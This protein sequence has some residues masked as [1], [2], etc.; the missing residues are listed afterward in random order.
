MQFILKYLAGPLIGAVIGYCTNYIAVKM[1][2]FPKREVRVFGKRLPFTPGAIPKG[3][4]RLARA[5]GQ[6]VSNTLI[7]KEDIEERLL[8]EEN[9][10]GITRMV[11][12]KVS[13]SI[14]GEIMELAD[15]S[16]ETYCEKR[17]R[18]TDALSTE[19][20]DSVSRMDLADTLVEKGGEVIK[21]KVNGTMLKM[22]L[23]DDRIQAY[24][25]PVAQELQ[26]MISENGEDYIRPIVE[27]KITRLEQ[28]TGLQLLS[29]IDIDEEKFREIISDGYAKI[30]TTG[31]EKFMESVN[32]SGIVEDKI[33]DMSVDTMEEMVLSV[34]KKELN[35]IV[36]LG[37]L[38]GL[39]LGLLNLV[40]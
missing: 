39:I 18:L 25:E 4:E 31:V 29:R 10:N 12:E 19:I 36:N 15:L 5:V 6:V 23:T 38:I 30:I 21:E 32:V 17:S 37:A 33:N 27:E 22:F 34:M 20:A 8:S 7:T 3:K 2:F 9:S 35:M 28:E 16:E 11:M 24:L 40:L 13:S 26:D 14:K 1:L